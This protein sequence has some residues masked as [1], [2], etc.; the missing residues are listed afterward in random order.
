VAVI[1]FLKLVDHARTGP[2]PAVDTGRSYSNDLRFEVLESELLQPFLILL[3]PQP[4]A[5]GA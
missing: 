4:L 5:I 2:A 1:V 3:I